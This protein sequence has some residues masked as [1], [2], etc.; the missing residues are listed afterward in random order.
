MPRPFRFLLLESPASACLCGPKVLLQR[1]QPQYNGIL[2]SFLSAVYLLRLGSIL[3]HDFDGLVPGSLGVEDLTVI[4]R[5][6]T[7]LVA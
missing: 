2:T 5:G 1:N 7:T 3:A 6:R 4:P